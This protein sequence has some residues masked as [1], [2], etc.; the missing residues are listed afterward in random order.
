MKAY[1]SRK[2][3]KLFNGDVIETL[4]SLPKESA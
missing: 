2:N 4:Q 3:I 1:Y